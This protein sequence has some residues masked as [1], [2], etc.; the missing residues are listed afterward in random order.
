[1]ENQVLSELVHLASDGID[2]L[3]EVDLTVSCAIEIV[4][5]LLNFIILES[6]SKISEGVFEFFRVKLS[7]SVVIGNLPETTSA[8]STISVIP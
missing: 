6:S 5:E 1:L 3:I 4:K 7:V 2:E 8:E